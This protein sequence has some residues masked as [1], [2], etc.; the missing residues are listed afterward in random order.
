MDDKSLIEK[1]KPIPFFASLTENDFSQLS[2]KIKIKQFRKN[3]IILYE[4]DTNEYMY[5]ILQG[6]VKVV[7]IS[8]EGKETILAIHRTG[9]FFGE[10]SLIDGKTVPA[11]VLST[12]NTLCAII[13]KGDFYSL[14]YSQEKIV[15]RLLQILC[16]RLRNSWDMIQILNFKNASQRLK[17]LFY[18][19]S[20]EYGK[21]TD[22]GIMLD[23][24]LTHRD[25]ANMAG[26]T[27][28]TVTRVLDKM[29]KDKE[30]AVLK[31]KAIR[32]SP[33]FLQKDLRE[34]L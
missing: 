34:G 18:L 27:R 10:M 30:I 24:K 14:L 21:K 19:L 7:Q 20:E 22:D 5:T 15:E 3:E 13:S 17:M 11:T 6:K 23:I 32:L 33:D 9:D 26:I 2:G 28:E 1:L 25:I 29:Q 16:S 4:E 8:E 12:E 31:N